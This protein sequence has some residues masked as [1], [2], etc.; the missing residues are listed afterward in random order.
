M[1]T[2]LTPEE[3]RQRREDYAAHGLAYLILLIFGTVCV[4]AVLGIAD[5]REAAVASVVFSV[6]GYAAGKLDP[7]MARYFR[8]AFDTNND[9]SNNH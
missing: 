1:P 6:M 2:P 9:S 8:Q 3:R 7:V 4:L 5:T